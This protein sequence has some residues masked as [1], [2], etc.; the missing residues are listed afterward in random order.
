MLSSLVMRGTT[1]DFVYSGGVLS[2]WTSPFAIFPGMTS[3]SIASA[4]VLEVAHGRGSTRRV[5]TSAE[6]VEASFRIVG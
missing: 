2:L 1:A 3:R 4:V 6:T 5:D